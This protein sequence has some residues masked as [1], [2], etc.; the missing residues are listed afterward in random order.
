[1]LASMALTHDIL[2][3]QRLSM[4]HEGLFVERVLQVASVTFLVSALMYVYSAHAQFTT[5][6][7][8]TL[9]EGSRVPSAYGAPWNLFSEEKETLIQVVCAGENTTVTLGNGE[10]TQFIYSVGYQKINGSWKRVSFSGLQNVGPW[11]VG[12]ATGTL[13]G[14]DDGETGQVIAYMCQKVAGSWKCGCSDTSCRTPKWQLQQ[15]SVE[16]GE[17]NDEND[18]SDENLG[19]LDVHRPSTHM[20]ISGA[21][22]TLYGE[23]FS[24]NSNEILWDGDVKERD[25][26]S[27]DGTTLTITVPNLPAG[28]Y[29]V[30]VRRNGEVSEYGTVI[31]VLEEGAQK[32]VISHITPSEIRQGDTITIHGSGFTPEYNDAITSFGVLDGLVSE[33]GTTITLSYD[34]FEEEQVFYH[35]DGRTKRSISQPIHVTVINTNGSSNTETFTILF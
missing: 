21:K 28:K 7:C 5:P 1:M 34:P 30:H 17:Q 14:V 3:V 31:W 19:I 22:I 23:G 4:K 29:E 2:R 15:F 16:K 12:E 10:A 26:P 9:E 13:Q 20:G 24:G 35:E 33:D 6:N 25:I 18:E 27:N 8:H 11:I 32:P